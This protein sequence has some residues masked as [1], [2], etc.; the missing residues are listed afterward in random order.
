MSYYRTSDK[1]ATS[2]PFVLNKI[3]LQKFS[4]AIGTPP[5]VQRVAPRTS[6]NYK[7]ALFALLALSILT[8][9]YLLNKPRLEAYNDC[10]MT[11]YKE[12]GSCKELGGDY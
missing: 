6:L 11:N 10:Y 1:Q 3:D 7:T 5:I 12:W 2:Q 8:L 4:S 9:L